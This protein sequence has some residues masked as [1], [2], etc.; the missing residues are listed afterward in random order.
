MI[1]SISWAGRQE[2]GR[3]ILFVVKLGLLNFWPALSPNSSVSLRGFMCQAGIML[4]APFLWSIWKITQ[5]AGLFCH[6]DDTCIYSGSHFGDETSL[7]VEVGLQSVFSFEISRSL[8]C[9]SRIRVGYCNTIPLR[10]IVSISWAGRQ[11]RGRTILFVVKE[12]GLA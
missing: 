11:E 3:T 10:M 2:R 4:A 1:V 6:L 7:I 8:L 5:V 12:V 9:H